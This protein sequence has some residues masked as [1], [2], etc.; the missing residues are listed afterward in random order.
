MKT[1]IATGLAAFLA[2]FALASNAFAGC[3]LFIC[4]PDG[5]GSGGG[6]P[7]AAP[8][9]DAS[10]V[11]PVVAIVLCMAAVLYSRYRKA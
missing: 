11:L 1:K 7:A 6:S 4:W 9:I 5:G 10:G 8:E 2:S 3:F